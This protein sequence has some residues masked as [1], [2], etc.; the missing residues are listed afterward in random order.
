MKTYTVKIY[1]MPIEYEI[2]AETKEEA[3]AIA[4]QAYNGTRY[5]DIYKV[6]V[7]K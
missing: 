3:E 4:M 5:D 1:P 2:E 6:T 7:T